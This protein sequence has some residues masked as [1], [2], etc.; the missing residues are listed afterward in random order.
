DVVRSAARVPLHPFGRGGDRVRDVEDLDAVLPG[1][2]VAGRIGGL[3][4][5]DLEVHPIA[6]GDGDGVRLFDVPDRAGLVE[7]CGQAACRGGIEV[8]VPDRHRVGRTRGR[9]ITEM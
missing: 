6:D 7:T 2:D 9:V 8:E 3:P 1:R 5:E 4:I